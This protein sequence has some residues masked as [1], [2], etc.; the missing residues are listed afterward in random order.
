MA[1]L[2]LALANEVRARVIGEVYRF[3][4]DNG[5]D[6]GMIAS[7]AVNMPAVVQDEEC[8]IEITV[9]VVGDSADD[10]YQKRADYT[11]KCAERAAKKA[12]R[13][14][15]AAE[16]KAKADAKRAEK[17]AQVKMEGV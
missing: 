8:F 7:N 10:C 9:K 15:A 5:E 3:L 4:S 1:K 17:A 12:E 16:R 11:A 14:K 6:V 13:E 2:K